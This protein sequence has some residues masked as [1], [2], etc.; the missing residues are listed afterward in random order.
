MRPAELPWNRLLRRGRLQRIVRL[1]RD[2]QIVIVS[3]QCPESD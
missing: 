1:A 3:Q 2:M